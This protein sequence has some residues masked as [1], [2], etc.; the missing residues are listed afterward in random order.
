MCVMTMVEL[1]LFVHHQDITVAIIIV[2]CFFFS[3]LRLNLKIATR[4]P[5]QMT[6]LLLFGEMIAIEP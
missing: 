1:N 4:R 2:I 3:S 6:Q 5:Q